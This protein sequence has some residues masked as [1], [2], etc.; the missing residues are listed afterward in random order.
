MTGPVAEL[1]GR[2]MSALRR[3]GFWWGFAILVFT[4]LNLAFW[5]SL[6]E[7]GSLAELEDSMGDLLEAFGAQGLSTPAG[8]LDGQL[9]ALMLPLLLSGAAIAMTTALTAG[10]EDAGRLELLHAL[11]LGRRTIWLSRWAAATAVLAAIV[12]LT[13]AVVSTVLVPFSLDE[14]GFGAVIAATFACGALAAFH[15]SVAYLVAGFGGSRGL[16]FGTSVGVLLV[17]YVV[18]FV[19]PISDAFSGARVWSPWNWAIGEQ[20]VSDGVG[21]G[22]LT[23]VALTAALVAVGTWAVERRDIRTT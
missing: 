20:P 15:A 7:S 6:E 10:D 3:S 13:T 14:A 4:L 21:L 23:I 16:A 9:Y 12:L 11:P 5:P 19:L 17:G 18:A 22:L 2:G 1:V 8:Y